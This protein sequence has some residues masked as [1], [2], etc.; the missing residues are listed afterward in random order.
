M[1]RT[2]EKNTR[3]HHFPVISNVL[4]VGK[5]SGIF[6]R[7]IQLSGLELPYY[8]SLHT[9]EAQNLAYCLSELL[10]YVQTLRLSGSGSSLK[11]LCNVTL[12]SYQLDLCSLIVGRATL[13]EFFQNGAN[14]IKSIGL[15]KT[16]LTGPDFTGSDPVELAAEVCCRSLG[17]N[18]P[19][20]C[21]VSAPC[22][23]CGGS[24]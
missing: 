12:P 2:V 21:W 4:N 7:T 11:P 14:S 10:K 18:W 23:V 3:G 9:S 5:G 13:C 1:D 6:I 20:S 8:S 22:L 17:L 16:R 24:G 19:T 15:R